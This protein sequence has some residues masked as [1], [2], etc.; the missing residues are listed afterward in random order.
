MDNTYKLIEKRY[1]EYSDLYY[2]TKTRA[3]AAH[4]KYVLDVLATLKQDIL[5]EARKDL[6]RRMEDDGSH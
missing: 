5:E 3:E 4:I 1:R 2:K 6:T